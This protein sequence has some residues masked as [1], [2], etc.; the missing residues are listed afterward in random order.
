VPG[1]VDEALE[2]ESPFFANSVC[3]SASLQ[4]F[5]TEILGVCDRAVELAPE[6]WWIRDCRAV[7]RMVAGNLDGARSDLEVVLSKAESDWEN[8]D[9]RARWLASSLEEGVN[10]LAGAELTE[11]RLKEA[12]VGWGL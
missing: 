5:A 7:A 10:S 11:F 4:G 6:E 12:G 3:W 2:S 1:T 9:Q 8:R